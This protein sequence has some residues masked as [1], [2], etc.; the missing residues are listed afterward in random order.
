M[1]EPATIVT[2]DRLTANPDGGVHVWHLS[3]QQ[4][5]DIYALLAAHGYPVLEPKNRPYVAAVTYDVIDCPIL[6]LELFAQDDNGG[7]LFD[8]DA[9]ECVMVTRDVLL[10]TPLPDWWRPGS[11]ESWA[12]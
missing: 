6:H 10:R 5:Q 7:L 3:E 8:R 4:R 11:D 1:T 2:G 9:D 12:I